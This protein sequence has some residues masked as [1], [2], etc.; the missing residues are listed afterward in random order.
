M[1]KGAKAEQALGAKPAIL[2]TAEAERVS[3]AKP[4]MF[5]NVEPD[6]SCTDYFVIASDSDTDQQP[7]DKNS[8]RQALVA[9]GIQVVPENGEVQDTVKIPTLTKRQKARARA[10]ARNEAHAEQWRIAWQNELDKQ[11]SSDAANESDMNGSTV[12][13]CA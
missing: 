4:A 7:F 8:L 1:L 11:E 5:R 10:K 12:R 9:R 2:K 6:D 3:G 13:S